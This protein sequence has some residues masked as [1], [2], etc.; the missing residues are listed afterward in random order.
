MKRNHAIDSIRGLLLIFMAINHFIWITGGRSAI[1][2]FTL[3]PLGQVGAAEGFVFI[4]G[5]MVG[6]IY[7][8]PAATNVTS[9]LI[10]RAKQLYG[11]H[12]GALIL[13]IVV[14]ISISTLW[15]VYPAFFQTMFPFLFR[16]PE[17]ATPLTLLLIHKPA[18]FDILPM[19][20]VFMLCA[21]IALHL[22]NR[23][24]ILWVIAISTIIWL[25]SSWVDLSTQIAQVAP[26]TPIN[27]GYFNWLAWQLPFMIGLSIGYCHHHLSINWFKYRL[28]LL[29]AVV[30]A[31]FIFL[32]HHN[33]FVQQFGLHQGTL[34]TLGNK[35]TLGWLRV[36]NLALLIYLLNYLIMHHPRLLTFR[37]LAML[38]RHS[39]QV[40]SWHYV[41][42]FTL[43]PFAFKYA[44]TGPAYNLMLAMIV[45]L[46]FIP[47]FIIEKKKTVNDSPLTG[48]TK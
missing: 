18:Y 29:L 32:A 7:C 43:A 41:V 36:F 11:Y 1:Q 44:S 22:L 31:V 25:S 2:L 13:I 27:T 19:Y 6:L 9:K 48:M 17:L 45:G 34:Y 8:R 42:I 24:K 21:P 20:I 4:S 3:Q 37:P 39:L 10:Q 38:G 26:I 40:F 16:Q 14:A 46:L 33:V 12:I 47:S 35:P 28:I 30:A 5:L 23:G 15:P